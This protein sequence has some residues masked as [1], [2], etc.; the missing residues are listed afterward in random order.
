MQIK[1]QIKQSIDEILN[2][3]P[4]FHTEKRTGEGKYYVP[5]ME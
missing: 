5:Y 3:I 4:T 1:H 2:M